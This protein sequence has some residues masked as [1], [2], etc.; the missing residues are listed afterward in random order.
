MSNP[1]SSASTAIAFSDGGL[2]QNIEFVM[3]SRFLFSALFKNSFFLVECPIYMRITDNDSIEDRL[4]D[5][6]D[7]I[8]YLEKEK[9][10]LKKCVEKAAEDWE[11]SEAKAYAKSHRNIAG[12]LHVLKNL[13]HP[14]FNERARLYRTLVFLEEQIKTYA[15]VP[16]VVRHFTEELKQTNQALD[17]LENASY[18]FIDFVCKDKRLQIGFSYKKGALFPSM[19]K[20]LRKI[21]FLK[22]GG[23]RR[24]VRSIH[25]S[26]F[27][28]AQKIKQLLAVVVFD[29]FGRSCF[30]NPAALEI[31]YKSDPPRGEQKDRAAEI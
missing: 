23:L 16:K 26:N 22:V 18:S 27:K 7:L 1:S 29:V 28:D 17:K 6:E 31:I 24:F 12:K 21:G 15:D 9:E 25:V 19:K 11:F 30:D 5:L 14:G 10:H 2:N 20:R 4:D 3:D 8:C 13:R